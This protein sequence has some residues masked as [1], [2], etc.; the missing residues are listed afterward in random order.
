[1]R[2]AEIR[3]NDEQPVG[4]AVESFADELRA[5]RERLGWSQAELGERMGYSGSHVSSVETLGR[6]PTLVFAKKADE[7]MA[8]PPAGA[9]P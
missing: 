5:W 7:A 9:R 6:T 8:T 3:V 2:R 1:M 4:M